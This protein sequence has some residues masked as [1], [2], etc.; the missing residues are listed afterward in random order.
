MQVVPPLK[1]AD[2]KLTMSTNREAVQ[3]LDLFTDMVAQV[4]GN[5]GTQQGAASLHF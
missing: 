3:M 5:T 4:G 2:Y 1:I